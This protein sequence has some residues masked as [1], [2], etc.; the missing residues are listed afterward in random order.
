MPFLKC[1]YNGKL[2][3]SVIEITY[4]LMDKS[5][6]NLPI[7]YSNSQQ[8]QPMSLSSTSLQV[9]G[10]ATVMIYFVFLLNI[11]M[12]IYNIITWDSHS[13]MRFQN[14]SGFPY[15]C[16]VVASLILLTTVS[17][18]IF[19]ILN[20]QFKHY[21]LFIKHNMCMTTIRAV[22]SVQ[23]CYYSVCKIG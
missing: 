14:K 15:P 8:S 1:Y 17:I 20:Y 12:Y 2:M 3:F 9:L 7:T 18:N 6:L 11:Y 16:A 5:M 23:N 22:H 19:C 13:F 10:K 21:Y 4:F